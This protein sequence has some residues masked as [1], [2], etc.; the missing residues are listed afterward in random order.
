MGLSE[1]RGPITFERDE[2]RMR[3]VKI[4]NWA[5]GASVEAA[6]ATPADLIAVLKQN[7]ALRA[8]VLKA[9]LRDETAFAKA[10]YETDSVSWDHALPWH[11]ASEQTRAH[12][13]ALGMA[14]RGSALGTLAE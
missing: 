6:D 10:I 5:A 1:K 4:N 2:R 14:A 7:D 9:V 3:L 12:Y 8:E 11:R 13:F